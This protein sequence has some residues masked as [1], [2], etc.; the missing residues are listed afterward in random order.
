M[1]GGIDEMD[2][3]MLKQF[4]RHVVKRLVAD[5]DTRE[6]EIEVAVPGAIAEAAASGS[7]A[8]LVSMLSSK[9]GHEKPLNF[10]HSFGTF[11]LKYDW[12]KRLYLPNWLKT[13]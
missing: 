3:P 6:V 8:N 13:G 1:G 9:V 12:K 7:G 2:R 5:L 11:N 10:G 4:I